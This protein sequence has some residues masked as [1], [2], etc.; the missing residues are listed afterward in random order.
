MRAPTGGFNRPSALPGSISFEL[1]SALSRSSS[2]RQASLSSP[3]SDSQHARARQLAGRDPRGEQH[4]LARP[5]RGGEQHEPLADSL[6]QGVEEPLA[7]NQMA[8]GR[9]HQQLGG[10]SRGRPCPLRCGAWHYALPTGSR[11]TQNVCSASGGEDGCHR[12]NIL[13]LRKIFCLSEYHP[14]SYVVS[15]SARV[16]SS[17]GGLV[18]LT[19]VA[20]LG[21]VPVLTASFTY[22]HRP[23]RG[24]MLYLLQGPSGRTGTPPLT[25]RTRR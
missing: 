2:S 8:R 13:P 21:L 15:R 19:P 6:V 22:L 24:R 16:G 1:R 9:R 20:H 5:G 4:G 7:L 10:H 11:L 18:K 3:S 25:E 23:A 12:P 14:D 17:R